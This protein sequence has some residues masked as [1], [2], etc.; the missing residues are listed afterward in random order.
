MTRARLRPMA[1]G[2]ALLTAAACATGQ[3]GADVCRPPA[4]GATQPEGDA[5]RLA[6]D[7]ALT[8]VATEGPRTG[9]TVAGRLTLEPQIDSLRQVRGPGGVTYP[10]VTSPLVGSTTVAV[11][12]VGAMVGGDL[13][14]ADPE[15]PGV[16]VLVRPGETLLRLGSSANRPGV[17]QFDGPSTVMRAREADSDGFGGVWSSTGGDRSAAGYFCAVRS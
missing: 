12:E 2:I 6:G 11:D 8:L 13:T 5:A 3:S 16:L 10:G 7:Y 4:S 17:L 1:L 15:A 14:S 9:A